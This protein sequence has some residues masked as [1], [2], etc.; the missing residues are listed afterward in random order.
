[1]KN[2]IPDDLKL[3]LDNLISNNSIPII[4]G[5]SVRDYF[6]NINTSDYDIEVYNVKSIIVLEKI[7]NKFGYVDIVGKSFA[8]LKLKIKNNCY[9]FSLPRLENKIG[10]GH[11]GFEVIVNSNLDFKEASKRRDFTINAIGYDYKVNQF[12]DPYNGIKDIKNKTLRHIDKEKFIEDPL[13][14]Y[15]AVQFIGRF[16]LNINEETKKLCIDIKKTNE[17]GNLSKDRVFQEY[18]KLLLKSNK[19]S[20]GLVLLNN[21]GIKKI[22]NTTLDNI[23][24]MVKF[25]VNNQYDNTI[26]M[27]Y[28][29]L[30]Y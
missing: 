12:L 26:L 15:R 2:S 28:F 5:G 7:L 20:L 30:K 17:F 10:V 1:M 9:D 16:E 11:K 27:F 4:V 25:K 19:P 8:V 3:V 13:R 6:F 23:D 14:V 29:Y 18:K 24:D 21:L 22:D